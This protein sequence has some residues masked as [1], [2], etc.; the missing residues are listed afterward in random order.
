MYLV[1]KL[2]VY[3]VETRVHTFDMSK[4]NANTLMCD[5]IAYT[6]QHNAMIY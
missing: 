3:A 5:E 6:Y 2:E 1:R 4:A